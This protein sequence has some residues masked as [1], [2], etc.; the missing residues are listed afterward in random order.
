M[1]CMQYGRNVS[2]QAFLAGQDRRYHH[3]A[4]KAIG[5]DAVPITGRGQYSLHGQ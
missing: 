4:V 1:Q 2:R 3:A 5:S